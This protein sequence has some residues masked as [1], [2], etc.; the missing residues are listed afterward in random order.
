MRSLTVGFG[1]WAALS[2]LAGCGANRVSRSQSGRTD[3]SIDSVL[4]WQPLRS[5]HFVELALRDGSRRSGVLHSGDDSTIVLRPPPSLA[6]TRH[7]VRDTLLRS[8][9][10]GV[11]YPT[12]RVRDGSPGRA[13]L[14]GILGGLA[15]IGVTLAFD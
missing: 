15:L 5:G 12:R 6:R 10:V 7:V 9:I 3:A 2:P 8:E 4:V 13:L 11:T 14:V 1:L